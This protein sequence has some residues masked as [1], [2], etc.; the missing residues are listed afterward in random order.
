MLDNEIAP[1]ETCASDNFFCNPLVLNGKPLDYT[2][3]SI[4]SQG[5]FCVVKGKPGVQSIEKI[6][7]RI[8]LRRKGV[9][10]NQGKSSSTQAVLSIEISEVL[11][12]AWPGDHLIIE[13]VRE[14]DQQAKRIIEVI[15]G[16]GDGC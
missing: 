13:P 12:L 14:S 16:Q 11:K 8:Y 9:I 10:I 15:E 7:F 6:P 1:K 3:F 2:Q 5:Q 4:L